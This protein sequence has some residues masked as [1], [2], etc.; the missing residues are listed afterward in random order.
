MERYFSTLWVCDHFQ[1]FGS[2]PWYE[3]WTALSYLAGKHPRFKFG[4]LVMSV[5]YRNPSMV[6]RMASTF[7]HLTDGRLI[8]GIGAGWYKEEYEAYGYRFPPYVERV[9]RLGE[10]C[11]II[12]SMWSSSPASFEGKYFRVKG[13]YCEPKP[14]E[15]I[16]LLVAVGGNLR[17]L[18]VVA[19]FADMYNEMG[20]VHVMKPA[21]EKLAQACSEIGRDMH[22]IKVTCVAVPRFTDDANEFRQ[23]QEKHNNE[24]L[25]PDV[26]SAVQE[27][28]QLAGIGVSH[29]QLRCTDVKSFTKFCEEVIPQFRS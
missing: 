19:K 27:I 12:R 9:E 29:M 2:V 11:E 6:A 14:K 17:A 1:W 10:A 18:R 28:R 22:E 13:A 16:P 24:L 15:K 3:G 23:L 21:C 8:L 4:N 5:G 20:R 25:G 7:Q 26:E